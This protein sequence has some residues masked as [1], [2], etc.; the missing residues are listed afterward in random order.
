MNKIV[1]LI[2]LFATPALLIANGINTDPKR[3]QEIKTKMWT[4]SEAEFSVKEVPD[5]WKDESAVILAKSVRLYFKKEVMIANLSFDRYTHT[6]VKLQNNKAVENYAQFE[7]T[8][9]F[10]KGS[11]SSKSYAGFKIIKANGQEIEV[12]MAGMR[13]E[14]MSYNDRD[15][16]IYKLAIPN[17]EVGDI[18][19]YYECDEEV[20]Y[21]YSSKFYSFDPIIFQ[22][23][24]E[25]PIVKQRISFEVM[26]RCYINLKTM[27]G[28]PEFKLT[29]DEVNDRSFYQLE[30][31]DRAGI[32]QAR[33]LFLN[34][35]L[36]TVKFKVS[37]ASQMMAGIYPGFLGEPG[38]VKNK[39]DQAEICKLTRYFFEI[40]PAATYLKTYM[41]RHFSKEKDT[42]RLVHEAYYAIRNHLLMKDAE[43]RTLAGQN[44]NSE[45]R[46]TSGMVALSH[47][48][49]SKK[50]DHDVL[51]A[52]PRQV[53][54]LQDLILEE[55]MMFL[56]RVNTPRPL[57]IGWFHN[58][59][60]PGEIDPDL[61]GQ[62]TYMIKGSEVT[63]TTSVA[64][65]G[66]TLP[67]D[68]F[69]KNETIG[70]YS[71]SLTDLP[72]G[73]AQ[74]QA[75]RSIQGAAR[76]FEQNEIMDY[77]DFEDEESKKIKP[78][79]TGTLKVDKKLAKQKQDFLNQRERERSKRIKEKVV[80]EFDA[81]ID[82]VYSLSIIQNGRYDKEP[83]FIYGFIADIGEFTKSAGAN[84][85]ITP[86]QLFD[87]QIGLTQ[88]EEIRNQ[89]IYFPYP[90]ILR[91]KIT[92][93]IPKDYH[94][95]GME[96]L[97]SS[98]ENEIGGFTSTA[99]LEENSLVVDISKIYKKQFAD[100]A[101]WPKVKAFLQ[102]S[103]DLSRKQVLLEKK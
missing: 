25:Y 55:E 38:K 98:V 82:S 42:D 32:P 69:A 103:F 58:H 19:D 78:V 91:Y 89:N 27:N 48:F 51:V 76:M 56:L 36:P 41:S 33:W 30:D 64:T 93:Q 34:R 17:L 2:Y 3:A 26:R 94:V 92:I 37:Y 52:I 28:A 49:R 79:T 102:A 7:L 23:Q 100:K 6:R 4:N 46:L 75:K 31:G 15:V 81:K 24:G 5:K 63:K 61:Q 101:D 77:F 71:V 96:N 86:G 84:Y 95:R 80:S 88:E 85:L 29:Q 53:S 40:N 22:L 14:K 8:G 54:G 59:S 50:I 44:S 62:Q 60:L 74:I 87:K 35:E 99:R 39:V 16:D 65:P 70:E 12:S 20:I 10:T 73:K 66:P 68:L 18:L 67:I 9:D 11:A 21:L 47:F 83:K 90:R 45:S 57:F 13:K 97:T 1:I 72:E 43:W